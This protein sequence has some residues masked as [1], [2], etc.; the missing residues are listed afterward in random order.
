ML[1]VGTRRFQYVHA[2][3]WKPN[4]RVRLGVI[5]PKKNEH[6]LPMWYNT[7][8]KCYSPPLAHYF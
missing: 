7:I 5:P 4:L 8:P 3:G 6:I 1:D 2:N